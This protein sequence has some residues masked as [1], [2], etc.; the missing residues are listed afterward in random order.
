LLRSRIRT[1]VVNGFRPEN[2]LMAVKGE[3]V[4]TLI[5]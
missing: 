1:V 5:S 3:K 4:G 2:V